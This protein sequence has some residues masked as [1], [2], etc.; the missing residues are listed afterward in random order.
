MNNNSGKR[1]V[2]L[3]GGPGGYSCAFMLADQG[4]DVVVVDVGGKLGG[5][6]LHTG[7]IPSKALLHVGHL[8]DTA[9]NAKSMGIDFD[10]PRID[11][12]I[13]RQWK[14]NIVSKMAQG[15]L[16][17]AKKRKVRI[18]AGVGFFLDAKSLK[19]GDEIIEFD[20]AIIATGSRPILLPPFDIESKYIMD[21]TSALDLESLPKSLLV[22]GGGYIGLEMGSFYSLLGSRVTIVEMTRELLSGTDRDLVH[23]LQ[24]RLRREF[25]N[26]RLNAKVTSIEIQGNKV[27]ATIKG[28]TGICIEEFDR[29]M[30]SV[31]R[32]P[33]T[34]G[35]G[36]ENTTIILDDNGFIRTDSD[37]KTNEPNIYAI[38]DV[39][40]GTMLAHK[41]SYE[42]KILAKYLTGQGGA[43]L[44]PLIPA[45][46]YTDPEIAWVGLSEI[47]AR[48]TG[49]KVRAS[50]FPWAASGRLASIGRSE[51]ITKIICEPETDCILGVGI[52]G[53]GAGELIAEGA[54]AIEH[55]LTVK[56]L[57]RI[58]HPHPTLSE[59][60]MEAAEIHLGTS[61]HI[62]KP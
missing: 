60:L 30:V 41:A 9:R 49:V 1:V 62:Y 45:V 13:L 40:G 15:L 56:D 35:I 7:C 16:G 6:C 21:S 34:L 33:N 26:I 32:Q 57:A 11:L 55:G 3:G 8:I 28:D 51:G 31:G 36:L 2:V 17:L 43:Q 47:S 14:N 25:E 27:R 54:L 50:S 23:P 58:I 44:N 37:G 18:I 22:V 5:V 10:E 53:Y 29:V 59:T 38:G 48:V 46:I 42:G 24:I 12:D 61:T 19:V 4:M 20:I 39:I 52:S